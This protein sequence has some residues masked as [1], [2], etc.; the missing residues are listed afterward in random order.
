MYKLIPLILLVFFAGCADSEKK[1][2][3]NPIFE[4]VNSYNRSFQISD[5]SLNR[6]PFLKYDAVIFKDSIGNALK[7][8]IREAETTMQGHVEYKRNWQEETMIEYF[9]YN[10]Q[11]EFFLVNES[12]ECDFMFE[13]YADPNNYRLEQGKTVRDKVE[14]F[15]LTNK[16]YGSNGD[17][18][19]YDKSQIFQDV[20]N[21][22]TWTSKGFNGGQFIPFD[23]IEI[24]GKRFSNFLEFPHSSASPFMIVFN[25]EFGLISFEDSI[26]ITWLFDSF[27]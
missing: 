22:R 18:E 10:Q 21:K 1:N 23:E 19:A 26:G 15:A 27:E 25:Y 16:V 5:T 9:V 6:M 14:M 12:F 4:I 13:I 20:I 17:Y 11:K 7:F 8:E 24:R 2:E 3:R